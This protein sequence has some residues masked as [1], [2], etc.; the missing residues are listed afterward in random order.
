M[1]EVGA[2]HEEV[3]ISD[4]SVATFRRSSVDGDVF[5]GLVVVADDDPAFYCRIVREILWRTTDDGSGADGVVCAHDDSPRN[6]RTWSDVASRTDDAWA[7]D[8]R[9]GADDDIIGELGFFRDEGSGVDLRHGRK[10]VQ[11]FSFI[12]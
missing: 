5:K 7:V 6:G 12:N 8:D 3:A 1:G 9:I 4:D 10:M 11:V 2:R